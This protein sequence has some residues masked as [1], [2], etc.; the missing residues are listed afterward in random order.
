MKAKTDSLEEENLFQNVLSIRVVGKTVAR[1][2]LTLGN[3]EVRNTETVHYSGVVRK[4]HQLCTKQVGLRPLDHLTC[5][6]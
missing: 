6:M 2:E 4:P 5:H 1:Y 3:K